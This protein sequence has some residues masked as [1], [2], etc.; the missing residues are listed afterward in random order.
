MGKLI[1]TYALGQIEDL[2]VTATTQNLA[3][4]LGDVATLVDDDNKVVTRYMYIY[5]RNALV[6]YGL[7]QITYTG[8]AG[9]EVGA[10]TFPASSAVYIQPC[11]PQVAIAS[12]S[13]GWVAIQGKCNITSTTDV[14]LGNVGEGIKS[15]ATVS[16]SAATAKT[17]YAVCTFYAS[18]TGTGTVSCY[19]YGER[20][21][22]AA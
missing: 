10:A 13:Y 9:R 8:T 17:I 11:V 18:R 1:R 5:A 21:N 6:K 22:I 12:G 19:L 7:Y 14:T 4:R 20:I 3:Y 15:I 2:T 16:D